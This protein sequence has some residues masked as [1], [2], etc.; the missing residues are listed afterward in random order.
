MQR[1]V[2]EFDIVIV[3]AGPA[4]LSA[5]CR[6]GQLAAA[7]GLEPS[8]C[9][10]EKASQIGGHIVSGAVLEPRALEELFPDWRELGAPLSTPARDEAVHW[11]A[12]ERHAVG[13][14]R[15]LVPRVMHNDGNYIVS[16]G[17]LCKWLAQRAE[18][19]GCDIFPGFAATEV[20]YDDGGCV[21][22]V[23]T[24]DM[25]VAADGSAKPN[26]QAGIELRARRV[27][28]AEGCRGSL[29]KDLERRFDLRAGRDPQ[30]YGLGLKEIWS[31]AQARHEPGRIVHTFGWPLENRTEGGGFLYHAG[32]GK[33]YLG[34]VVALNYANPHLSPFEEFQRWKQHPLVRH[35]LDGGER[36]AFGARAVNKGGLYS[37]PRMAFPGGMLVGCEAG[38]L[39]GA[40]IKGI[41]TAMKSGMLAA[42]TAFAALHEGQDADFDAAVRRSWV[43]RELHEARNFSS[44]IARFGTFLGAGLAFVEHNVLR[45]RTPLKLRNGAPDHTKLIPAAEAAPIP[46]PAPDGVISFDRLSSVYLS[47]IHHDE[48][49]PNHLRLED[50][51]LPVAVNLPR[52]D[53][54]AQ[55][56]CPAAVYEIVRETNGAPRFQINAQNCVHCKTCDIKDP[57][58]NINWQPPE[59]GS[60]P[61]YSAM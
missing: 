52:F 2:M 35:V 48:D 56:Y 26:F 20:C 25:G 41:H 28:F 40:K 61:N 4:G 46:Y 22:G 49:Q 34:F 3:G 11:L 59:G 12:D 18:A 31:V 1:D 36:I 60:G 53:E 24:G 58:L 30:H 21:T 23:V 10:L 27:I 8:V 16:L 38:L 45:G 51:L 17:R 54:P 15:V 42:E 57:A 9:V 43:G 33:A 47:D 14:P 32:D 44:G 29:G 19:L 7:K 50:P 39:N 6:F 37:L 13:V 55:R 5:A